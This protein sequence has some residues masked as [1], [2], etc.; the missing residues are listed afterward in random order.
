MDAVLHRKF[1]FVLAV[2]FSG[3]NLHFKHLIRTKYPDKQNI[4]ELIIYETEIEQK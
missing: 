4:N 2:F 3:G 1:R